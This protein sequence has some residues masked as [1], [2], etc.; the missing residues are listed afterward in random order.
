MAIT[1]RRFIFPNIDERVLERIDELTP[2][3]R[4]TV[5]Q[6]HDKSNSQNHRI[7]IY[8]LPAFLQTMSTTGSDKTPPATPTTLHTVM[9]MMPPPGQT[10]ALLFNGNK[11]TE[12]FGELEH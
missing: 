12:F 1:L 7:S 2:D 5:I 4:K 11:I 8:Q 6:Q 3:K 9:G 10:D